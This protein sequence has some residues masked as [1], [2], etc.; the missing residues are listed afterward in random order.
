MARIVL[1]A[2]RAVFTDFSGAEPLGFG[3]CIP[4][5]LVPRFV[6][7][8]VLAPP[9][10]A[11]DG[12]RAIFAP[13]PLCKVEASLLAAGFRR[14]DVIITPPEKLEGVV[15]SDT[16]VVGVHVLDPQGL[17]PV[18][19]TLRVLMGGGET[20][21]QYEFERLM[22]RVLQLKRRYRFKVVVG[23]PGVWQ[24]RGLE[25][26]FGID[27]LF[28]G[29]AEI[30]FPVLISKIL[31][32]E[33]VPGYVVGEQPAP[34]A[35][36]TIVTPSRNG[37]VQITRGCPR[38]CH[39]CSPT[40]QNFR[41]IPLSNILKEVKL[42]LEHGLHYVGFATEDVLLYGARGIEPNPKAV[43]NL[44]TKT[45]ELSKRY[46]VERP[47]FTHVSLS[48]AL[49]AK[50]LVKFITD[51][52][53]YDAHN[54][55][56]PQ[57]GLESGSPRIV[58]RY[59][60]GK[61]YPWKPEE[62]PEVVIS[63]TK[64]MNENYWYP[65]LTYIIGFPG[66]EPED[67]LRTTEL[68]EKLKEE[69]FKGWTFPLFLVPIGGTLIEKKTGFKTLQELPQE[70]VESM[71]VG[72]RLSIRFSREVYPKILRSMKNRFLRWLL[73]RLTEKAL[74]SLENWVTLISRDPSYIDR[75]VAGVKLRSTP[76]LIAALIRSKL[77]TS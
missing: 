52:C 75:L 19:W 27:V 35:I 50:E 65:C 16:E 74:D 3:L 2:D 59:F 70:A 77:R 8:W 53:G 38:K 62:W 48:T 20:C 44:F 60:A 69:G 55:A 66:A 37:I 25:K 47:G 58:A 49:A 12:G 64:L 18:S 68:L 45:L 41:S 29:E 56:F 28:E 61:P 32:G 46:G 42:N 33:E 57:V 43:K 13:Y 26:K 31:K 6:E 24:L 72:W 22:M 11:G 51:T 63:S 5:R 9:V 1:T 30:T 40:M 76:S 10:P 4:Y 34:E 36:P 14:S 67:Y 17:A 54:P 15:S 23:G 7:Y 39:F 73:E 21:T 71:V